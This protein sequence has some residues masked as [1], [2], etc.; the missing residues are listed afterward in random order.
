MKLLLL[1]GDNR[2]FYLKK[3][4]ENDGYSTE[5]YFKREDYNKNF[6]EFD[7]IILPYP[8][9]R[10]GETV[11]NSL[12]SDKLYL[13]ELNNKITN[14]K[15]LCGG[16]LKI[17]NCVDY[18]NNERLLMS[19]AVLTAEGALAVAINNTDISL[20]RS[21]C[22]IIGN[23]R[24]G[25]ILADRLK[26]LGA[27]VTVSARRESDFAFIEAF[28]Q[29]YIKTSEISDTAEN[30]NIIFNTVP[31]VVID[32]DILSKLNKDTLIIELAS[33]PYGLNFETA[34]KMGIKA[35]LAAALPGKT[36][37][38]SAAK[39]LKDTIIQYL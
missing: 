27:E 33:A 1:G 38:K 37:P 14:Q 39:I 15:V 3:E 26:K 9:T 13:D 36:A 5:H 29:K 11:F 18:S 10:D 7:A 32:E 22:L 30:Y 6:T 34:K 19:N 35:I 16:S 8:T 25:K 2:Q 17:N 23:G 12:S 20:W 24:I 28:G 21:R 31:H 4:L